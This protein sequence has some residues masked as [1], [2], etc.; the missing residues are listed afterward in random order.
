MVGRPEDALTP[1]KC[2]QC[3]L[4]LGSY[5]DTWLI[6]GAVV[7]EDPTKLRCSRCGRKLNWRPERTKVGFLTC[8]TKS[9]DP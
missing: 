7:F 3:H 8:D 6:V 9:A 5:A 2:K 4:L 1:L